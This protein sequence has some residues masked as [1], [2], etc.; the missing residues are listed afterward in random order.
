MCR[1]W[2][3]VVACPS[4]PWRRRAG[5]SILLLLITSACAAPP[6]REIVDAE[7]AL[8]AAR[9]AGAERYATTDA[10]KQAAE[11]YRLANE[12]VTA[13]DY[14]LALSKALES[15]EH[16]QTAERE[17]ADVH[18]RAR[19]EVLQTMTEVLG[20]LARAG[21]ELESAERRRVPRPVLR[22]ARDTLAAID[23]DVQEAS[24]AIKQ[25]DFAGAK[26]TLIGVKARLD[27]TLASLA[28]PKPVQPARRTQS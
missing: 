3:G 7:N 20:L 18:A 26:T 2:S 5:L 8:K 28:D 17:A 23:A 27:K 11:A 14:R 4:K 1:L 12:A 24:A 15:R 21:T 9:A 22:N 13:G 25:Q 6:N 10:Y 19:D 16:S